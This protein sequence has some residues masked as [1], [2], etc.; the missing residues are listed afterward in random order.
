MFR[1]F[2]V[3]NENNVLEGDRVPALFLSTRG[4]IKSSKMSKNLQKRI[5]SK[6]RRITAYRAFK[7]LLFEAIKNWT[8]CTFYTPKSYK[9]VIIF[10]GIIS[11]TI[12][13]IEKMWG[14]K[15]KTVQPEISKSIAN[16]FLFPSPNLAS[17]RRYRK[18]PNVK[19]VKFICS[20]LDFR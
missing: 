14:N 20:L 3:I 5:T 11:R 8:P 9:M 13:Y 2:E 7:L 17:F 18:A 12:Y 4:I 1:G 15:T 16:L 10:N 19:E 6:G